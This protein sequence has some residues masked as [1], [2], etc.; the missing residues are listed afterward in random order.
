MAE[1]TLVPTIEDG[2]VRTNAKDLLQAIEPQL[3]KFDYVVTDENVK[4]AKTDRASLNNLVKTIQSE[5]KKIE[6]EVFGEWKKEKADIMQLE[7]RLS[8][9]ADNL[10]KGI[11]ELEEKDKE[12][13]KKQIEEFWY[14]LTKKYPFELVFEKKML[15]KTVTNKSIEDHLKK[16]LAKAME[17][18]KVV[19]TFLPKDQFQAEQVKD[20]YF[21]TMDL[22]KAKARADELTRI[23]QTVKTVEKTVQEKPKAEPVQEEPKKV[24]TS[25]SPDGIY[26]ATFAVEGT[27]DDM[28]NLSKELVLLFKKYNIKAKVE[29][30][31]KKV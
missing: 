2:I 15:N 7:K 4:D 30:K 10:D 20:V 14:T 9:T 13:K 27:Y 26:G 24:V 3:K 17:G 12:L 25:S 6:D 21:R 19:E 29:K 23:S 31:W 18:E 8:F 5:R 16:V 28:A 11:K 22:A 1:F